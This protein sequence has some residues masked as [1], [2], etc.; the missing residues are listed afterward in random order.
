MNYKDIIC[1]VEHSV[2]LKELGIV[3]DSL[4][5]YGSPEGK[6]AGFTSEELLVMLPNCIDNHYLKICKQDNDYYADYIL[7]DDG[8][9][10]LSN[11][12]FSDKKLSNSLAKLLIWCVENGYVEVK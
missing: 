4:F 1:D 3:Q 11:D 5:S 10:F 8:E 2:K 7:Y 12:T 6:F 9:F